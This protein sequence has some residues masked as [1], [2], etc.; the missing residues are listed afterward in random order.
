M[1]SRA[2]DYVG[3]LVTA[4]EFQELKID[5]CTGMQAIR[6]LNFLLKFILLITNTVSQ[7]IHCI[8]HAFQSI[9]H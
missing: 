8:F 5:C 6:A 1:R 3:V 7:C 2:L 4:T 9:R